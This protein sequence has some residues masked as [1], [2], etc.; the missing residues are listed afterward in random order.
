MSRETLFVVFQGL[1]FGE[2]NKNLIKIADTSFKEENRI[3][4]DNLK[5]YSNIVCRF[6][7]YF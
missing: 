1:P 6:A 5:G 2:K 7:M 4:V 3:T